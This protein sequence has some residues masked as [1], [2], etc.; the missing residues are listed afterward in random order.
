MQHP[1]TKTEDNRFLSASFLDFATV[2]FADL[3]EEIVHV[4]FLKL[5]CVL[6]LAIE[7]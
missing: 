6:D 4:W 5:N 7:N 1:E 2:V 3:V